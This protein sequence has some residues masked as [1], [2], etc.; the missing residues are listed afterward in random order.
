MPARIPRHGN[1]GAA[2][3]LVLIIVSS[4]SVF[5]GVLMVLVQNRFLLTQ[6]EI[7][8]VKAIS[9]AEAAISL[10]VHELKTQEDEDEN[11]L[12]N[13]AER[14]IGEGLCFAEHRTKTGEI[15]AT[16]EANGVRR[17]VEVRYK[18]N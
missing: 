9:L 18:S 16:G 15:L 2:L 5:G 6:L 7:D 8:R 14:A 4:L 13:V 1:R 11:G 10:S 3:F 17:T 12:G